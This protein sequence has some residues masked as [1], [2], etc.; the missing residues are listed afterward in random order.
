M[1]R[2]SAQLKCIK[3]IPPNALPSPDNTSDSDSEILDALDQKRRQL[4]DEVARFKA[5]KDREFRE[6]EKQ[7]WITK[8]SSRAAASGSQATPTKAASTPSATSS[9][10]SLLAATQNGSANGWPGYKVKRESAAAGD[11]VRKPAPLSG[12]TLSL[13]KLNIAGETTPP[14]HTLGTPPTP[15]ILT[16][17]RSRS[18]I[19]NA[20]ARPT[21]PPTPAQLKSEDPPPSS[22]PTP[23]RDRSDP[24]AGVFTPMYLPLLE[25]RDRTPIVRS[26]QPVTSAEEEEKRLQLD[27]DSKDRADQLWKQQARSSQS[28]P[29]QP[30]SPSVVATK[31][32]QSTSVLPSASLP[33]ALRSASGGGRTRK[34]VM[35][36]L[37]DFK[38]VDP[39]SSYEEGPSPELEGENDVNGESA[40]RFLGTE[41]DGDRDNGERENGSTELLSEKDKR[42][43]RGRGGRFISPIPS[44]LAS[45]N[46][47]PSPS[48]ALNGSS[49]T[50]SPLQSPRLISSPDQ[51]GFSG[52]LLGAE[53]GG[54]GV[55]FFELD[56]ELASPALR[57]GRPVEAFDLEIE[58]EISEKMGRDVTDTGER[59]LGIVPSV[60]V[61]S[62]PI[63]IVRPSGS[64]VGSFG[65]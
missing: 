36:Q 13:E 54:S 19:L 32:A 11:K 59:G 4:D 56:E 20:A 65:H 55:G 48:P 57:E 49:P 44:P 23:S 51:S 6:F 9:A 16:R 14:L 40:H 53:D 35:F 7:L 52:G 8:K 37:A 10:L 46:P 64:W 2:N 47:S 27:A 39:S 15:S 28:L 31:R 17:T 41:E 18:P 30:V 34:H 5:A 12:P 50:P 25:S 24:F 33:S 43:G 21:T 61:G 26:P 60:Q 62:V 63:D 3:S 45:P 42:R 1:Y 22:T 29:P 58:E 38:V